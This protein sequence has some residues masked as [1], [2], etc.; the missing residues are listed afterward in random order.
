MSDA[1]LWDAFKKFETLSDARVMMD[2]VHNR[3]RG[4]GFVAFRDLSVCFLSLV[5]MLFFLQ[6]L[7]I[8]V[9]RRACIKYNEWL[10]VRFQSY[11]C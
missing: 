10:V 2:P 11:P 4:Y 3:S 7:I 5:M 9:G 8:H 1:L 6:L